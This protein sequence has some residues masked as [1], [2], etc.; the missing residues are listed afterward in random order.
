MSAGHGAEYDYVVVGAGTAGCVLAARLSADPGTRV[1][2]IEAGPPADRGLLVQ[3]PLGIGLLSGRK[4]IGWGYETEPEP[5]LNG[6]RIPV[7]RGRLV[8][9]TG[10]INGS[11]HVRA[12]HLDYDDWVTAGATGWGWDDLVPYFRRSEHSWRGDTEHHGGYGPVTVST[13]PGRSTFGRRLDRAARSLG[14]GFPDDTQSGD[15]TGAGQNETAIHRGRRH[16]TAAAYLRPALRRRPHLTLLTGGLVDT[17][18]LESGRATGVRVVK[19]GRSR[20]VRAAREVVL[21]GGTY[22]SPQILMRSGIGPAEHLHEHGIDTV[23][24]L[25][26]VGANL[27]E[28]PAAPVLFDVKDQVTFHE[29]LRADRL[30]RHALRWLVAGSGPLAQMPEFLSAYVRTRPG[31]DRPDGFL[32]ILAG[33][34]DARPWFPGVRP[35]RN[36]HCVALNAVATPRSRGEVRLRSADPTA[37]PRITF[38]LLTEP[39]DVVALRE[40]V[41]TTL[42]ILRSPEVA[43][44]IGAELAPGP[45]VTTD[46][47]LERYLRETG[48]SANHACGTCAIGTAESAVVDPDLRVRGIDGLRVVDASV[49]PSVPGAN[50]NAT[51]IAVAEKA[52]D[53][54]RGVPAVPNRSGATA[55]PLPERTAG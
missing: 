42:A 33:G 30:V 34:F 8:G 20:V 24:D 6:R 39:E 23:V 37:T 36:R 1:L 19:G 32:G 55:A 40:T 54:I 9:G 14:I 53:L 12:H 13:S 5:G 47:D 17:L 28:H 38:N 52:S 44:M 51:V 22:N 31:L 10:S 15:P 18:L 50:I 7:P 45:D 16:S 49:L 4:G 41:R 2:L 46:Q 3:M 11:T 27:Q 35:L 21:C 25:P 29:H 43:P 48:Y 26:G